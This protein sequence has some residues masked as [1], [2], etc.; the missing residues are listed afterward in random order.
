M[1][2]IMHCSLLRN[3][4]K[5]SCEMYFGSKVWKT[6][7]VAYKNN[8]KRSN[9]A[10]LNPN[11]SEDL[12]SFLKRKSNFI[13]EWKILEGCSFPKGL[14][15]TMSFG[16]KSPVF[17][18]SLSSALSVE[19]LDVS[20][21]RNYKYSNFLR[22]LDM[23]A[24][25]GAKT[26]LIAWTGIDLQKL[27]ANELLC[28]RR[29]K[30]QSTVNTFISDSINCEIS[31]MNGVE[32]GRL[33]EGQFDR[34]LVDAPCTNDRYLFDNRVTAEQVFRIQDDP[35]ELQKELLVSAIK[36]CRVGGIVVYSTCTLNMK[37]NNEII[38]WLLRQSIGLCVKLELVELGPFESLLHY[39][40]LEEGV[41]VLPTKQMNWG[42]LFVSKLRKTSCLNCTVESAS[43]N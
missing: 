38:R 10:W 40:R 37:Q 28:E 14:S 29:W 34:V 3:H 22:V 25:P 27:V 8:R 26:S 33:T 5:E 4:V 7:E 23:C 31:S 12:R 15:N 13:V 30:L 32:F 36:S 42:P 19:A 18:M 41:I 24:S 39:I 6:V 17:F 21:P 35:S 11:I 2:K 20:E 43:N 1:I 16:A 9:F